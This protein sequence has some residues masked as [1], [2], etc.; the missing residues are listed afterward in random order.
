MGQTT[1]DEAATERDVTKE[2]IETSEPPEAELPGVVT[3]ASTPGKSPDRGRS[4]V[5]IVEPAPEIAPA[6]PPARK[7]P[8][9]TRAHE[10]AEEQ[11]DI[12]ISEFFEQNR[13]ILG[14]DNPT[15]SL[16][17]AVKEAVDNAL[18]A[19]EQGG[20]LPEVQVVLESLGK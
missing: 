16:I 14:F 12:P 15:H 2:E 6:T 3:D 11:R 18:D 4:E 19:C 13:H 10:L 17:T 7:K 9:R 20:I 8:V 1:L 5:K